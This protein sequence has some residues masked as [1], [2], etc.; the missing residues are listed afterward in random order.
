M[1][2]TIIK[3][4]DR[5]GWLQEREK[6]IGS[7]E[8]G[9][10]LGVNPW[11]TPYQLW[12]IKKGLDPRVEENAAMRAGHILESAVA[13]YF[14]QETGHQVIKASEGD[15]LA[16]D[17]TRDFLRVSPDR[18]YWLDDGR[19]KNNK[20]ILE[21]KTT[22]MDIS[23]DDVP[24][25]WFCQLMYQLGV[26]GYSQGTLAWLT[27]GQKF[28]YR[29]INFD[30]D[31]YAYMV[32]QIER[33]WTDCIHGNQEPP[34]TTIDDVLVKFNRSKNGKVVEVTD[35]VMQAI[36]NIKSLKPQIKL[37]TEQKESLEDTVKMFM[38]DADTLCMPGTKDKNPA[39][40]CTWKSAKDTKKFDASR[41]AIDH[42]DLYEQYTVPVPGARRFIIK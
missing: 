11:Q 42:P 19:S 41:F 37:L 39:V 14:E 31:F 4:A 9:T 23:E 1:S 25:H 40:V 29:N 34:V 28:G 8:V 27:R 32:E 7:S 18:T 17:T 21:C 5:Q 38:A 2:Y 26:M 20:G 30:A 24:K 36:N 33:F 22:Q 3:P 13:T 35:E 16:V 10:I 12:R 6:G 15:W